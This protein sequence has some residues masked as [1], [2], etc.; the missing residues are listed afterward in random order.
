MKVIRYQIFQCE[1]RKCI[2][3]I[4]S[5]HKIPIIVGGTGLYIK[6]ALYD[7]EFSKE[8]QKQENQYD[9]LSNEELYQLLQKIDPATALTLHQNN[10][11][12]VIKLLRFLK[13][14]AKQKV[15]LKINN[16]IFVYMMFV[17]LD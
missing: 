9:H 3:E 16:N 13:Q 14:V 11:R 6:A 5:R 1:V 7:Y 17:L 10:R 4:Y 8:V 2:Q 12:R 15:K